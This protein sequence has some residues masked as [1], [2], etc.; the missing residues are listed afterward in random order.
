MVN[1]NLSDSF[2]IEFYDRFF[3]N[4]NK[5]KFNSINVSVDPKWAK[6]C[7]DL[8]TDLKAKTDVDLVK[9]MLHTNSVSFN[10]FELQD[11]MNNT[12][13]GVKFNNIRVCFG[14]Y[15]KDTVTIGGVEH[16]I[17]KGKLTVF[18]WPYLGN[19]KATRPKLGVEP[20]E[21]EVEPFNIGTLNP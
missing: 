21:E 16:K 12:L 9:N 19:E 17:R 6:V 3:S 11:W 4:F 1:N 7:T 20:G 14:V 2:K 15:D 13:S 8:Y 5:E 18:L 10:F